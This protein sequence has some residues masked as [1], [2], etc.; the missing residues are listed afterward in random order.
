MKETVHL[1]KELGEVPI[2]LTLARDI[3]ARVHA[4]TEKVKVPVFK[5]RFSLR[6]V[7]R[8]I[9][10]AT[11]LLAL[12]L[13]VIIPLR[14]QQGILLKEKRTLKAPAIREERAPIIKVPE[15]RERPLLNM[16]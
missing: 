4:Q 3:R 1:T 2:P 6:L 15:K 7:P 16:R 10:I 8:Y 11:G 5:E 12:L 9:L 13:M 14:I